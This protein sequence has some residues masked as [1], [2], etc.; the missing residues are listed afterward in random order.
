M[1]ELPQLE[2]TTRYYLSPRTACDIKSLETV[3]HQAVRFI[4]GEFNKRASVTLLLKQLKLDQ[5]SIR[6]VMAQ[7]MMFYK[8]HNGLVNI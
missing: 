2:Y 8:I 3:Q 1:G 6:R 7:C 4:C 5:L